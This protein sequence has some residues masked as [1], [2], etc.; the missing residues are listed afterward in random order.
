MQKCAQFQHV[1]ALSTTRD[2]IVHNI[3]LDQVSSTLLDDCNFY[4]NH[5]SFD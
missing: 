2:R 1:H 5:I 4:T 3:D